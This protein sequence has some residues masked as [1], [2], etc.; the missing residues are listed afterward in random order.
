M[1]IRWYVIIAD[2]YGSPFH[3]TNFGETLLRGLSACYFLRVALVVVGLSLAIPSLSC[4]KKR[5]LCPFGRRSSRR[6]DAAIFERGMF[7]FCF[8]LTTENMPYS[9]ISYCSCMSD[10][11]VIVSHTL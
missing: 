11:S 6:K 8:G 5:H 7:R 1:L 4:W 3:F 10:A 9:C 2:R